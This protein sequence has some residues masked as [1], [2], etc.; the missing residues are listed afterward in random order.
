[1]ENFS[2]IDAPMTRRTKKNVKFVWDN[3]CERGFKVVDLLAHMFWWCAIVM[4]LI[5]FILMLLEV[6]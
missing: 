1:M 3:D 2:R 4:N 6:S 5:Q